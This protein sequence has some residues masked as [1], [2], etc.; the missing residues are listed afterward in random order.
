MVSR[1]PRRWIL[2]ALSVLQMG[3][4]A[5]IPVLPVWFWWTWPQP[6]SA[7]A[8]IV[9]IVATASPLPATHELAW[10]AP[11]WERDLKQ[12]PIP[13]VAPPPVAPSAPIQLPILLATLVESQG[14]YA[15]FQGRSGL[16]EMKGLNETI[17]RFK[18]RAIEPGRVQ[19]EG[20]SGLVWVQ[21]PKAAGGS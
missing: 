20:D 6:P 15:H 21:I 11:L 4:L 12:P 2:S 5:A 17:D 3:L 14:R 16:A 7:S 19:L 18:V 1:H 10:Y 9:E 8:L 13:P